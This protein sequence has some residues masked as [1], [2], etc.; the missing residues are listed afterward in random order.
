MQNFLLKSLVSLPRIPWITALSMLQESFLLFLPPLLPPISLHSLPIHSS[1]YPELRIAK[2]INK[3]ISK[4]TRQERSTIPINLHQHAAVANDRKLR[5]GIPFRRF[6]G[7]LENSGNFAS[8]NV[9][10]NELELSCYHVWL[11]LNWRFSLILYHFAPFHRLTDF[12]RRLRWTA[13]WNFF[14]KWFTH[15]RAHMKRQKRSERVSGWS[16]NRRKKKFR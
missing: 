4:R 8:Q 14:A 5:R 16:I 12:L 1:L 3:R 15:S 2:I 6:L 9:R 13:K 11:Q 7:N 10:L